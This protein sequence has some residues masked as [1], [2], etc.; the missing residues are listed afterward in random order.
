[1]K[2]AGLPPPENMQ[3]SPWRNSTEL[4]LMMQLC[5][6]VSGDEGFGLVVATSHAQLRHGTLA[7]LALHAPTLRATLEDLTRFYPLG[8]DRQEL[9]YSV[10]AGT[11]VLDCEPLGQ[12]AADQRFRAEQVLGG[13]VVFLRFCGLNDEDFIRVDCRHPMPA[14]AARYEEVFG[15]AAVRFGEPGYR[16]VFDAAWLD[17]PRV[18][19]DAD[20]YSMARASAGKELVAALQRSSVSETVRRSLGEFGA[21]RVGM[22]DVAARLGMSE[23]TLRRQLAEEG[24]TFLEIVDA[25]K[26]QACKQL[27][28]LGTV[29]LKQIAEQAGYESVSNFHR[30]F[31]NRTGLTPL[32]WRAHQHAAAD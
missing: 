5:R 29:P 4:D 31:K 8:Q 1:M 2:Q 16:I 32:Q 15:A 26:I 18:L 22:K 13:L 9:R 12:D 24:T 28:L 21:G 14:Y 19:S 6:R 20:A 17:S 25:V 10:A 30:A 23:R 3:R 7:M 11:C 27:V